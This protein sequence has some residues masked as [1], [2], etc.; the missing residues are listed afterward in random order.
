M[1]KHSYNSYPDSAD[2]S[3][4]SREIDFDTPPPWEEQSQQQQQQQSQNYKAKFMCSYG[5]KI[6]PRPHDNQLAYVGG[7]TKILAVDRSIKLPVMISK[8]ASLCGDPD[9]S[10]KYQLPG[11]DLDAL[12]SVT[13]EDDLEHLMHEYDR[14]YRASAKPAR[15]RLFLFPVSS[16]GSF[17]SE[18]SRSERDRFVEALNLGP[19]QAIAEKPAVSNPHNVDF[20]FGLEKGMVPPPV[21]VRDSIPEPVATPPPAPLPQPEVPVGLAPDDRVIGS[22]HGLNPVEI[23][24]QLHELQRLQIREQEQQIMYGRKVDDNLVGGP[25][26]EAGGYYA[27]KLPEKS[28]P[29]ALPVN[30]QQHLQHSAGFWTDKQ[31]PAG[32]FPATMTGA[33]G[34][35]EQQVFMIPGP[36]PGTVYH[37]PAP[38]AMVRPVTAPA[39][40]GYYPNMQRMAADVYREQQVYNIVAQQPTQTQTAPPL[41]AA[42]QHTVQGQVPM[43]MVRQAGG[44]GGAVGVTDGGYAAMAYEG[45][46]GRQVYYTAGGGVVVSP[47]YQGV[48]TAVTGEMRPVGGG[49]SQETKVVAKVSQASV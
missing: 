20:L 36:A 42:G 24:R 7:E 6:Q 25:Y 11:E 28:S 33:P 3:P 34:P 44:S 22:D 30:I 45:G 9:V 18:G 21:K 43:G 15:M 38:A 46:V 29:V 48:G 17:G 13:N 41:S 16:T 1:E 27:Q 14:L 37:A 12:I 8:L 23:Q 26:A 10:F 32:G 31:I 39:G 2:S 40:Q 47:Q 19:A 49:L 4:R 35:P 5:G